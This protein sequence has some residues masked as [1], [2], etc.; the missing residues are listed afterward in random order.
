[1]KPLVVRGLVKTHSPGTPSAHRALAGV[2]LTV[3]A[4]EFV[5]I[6]GPSGSGKSTLL[7]LVALTDQPDAGTLQLAGQDTRDLS[8]HALAALRRRHLGHLHQAFNLLPTLTVLENVRLP[9]E[10]LGH[11]LGQADAR[12]LDLLESVGLS[13]ERDR[14][15]SAL[16]GGQQ[17][18]VALARAMIHQPGLVVADEPTGNL[19][20]DTGKTVLRLLCELL[21][22]GNGGVLMVTHDPEVAA[23]ADRTLTLV[24]GRFLP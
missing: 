13:R 16:S 22:E 3:E 17:Q 6:M 8:D 11:S 7:H 19:D 18:R 23:V 5:A 14:H 21:A 10:L 12:A 1:M 24:D 2:D 4:G 9:L 20:R 15:P